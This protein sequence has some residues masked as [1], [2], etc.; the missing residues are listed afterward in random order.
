MAPL[1]THREATG[2]KPGLFCVVVTSGTDS[3][4]PRERAAR[5]RT[6]AALQRLRASGV[7][8]AKS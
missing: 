5:P 1:S 8:T 2:R 7:R 4:G 3:R 6:H